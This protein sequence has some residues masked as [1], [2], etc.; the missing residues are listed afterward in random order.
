MV[1]DIHWQYRVMMCN[2]LTKN[3]SIECFPAK[4]RPAWNVSIVP[5]N[6]A[7]AEDNNT[8]RAWIWVKV[9]ARLFDVV[10]LLVLMFLME[11]Y[12]FKLSSNP[13]LERQL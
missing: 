1:S 3:I 5:L 12:L 11:F 4:A 13:N 9:V 7:V 2:Q 10:L 6:A 8:K